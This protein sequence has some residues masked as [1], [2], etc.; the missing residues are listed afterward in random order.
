MTVLYALAITAE[1]G[2]AAIITAVP[3]NRQ[4]L[5]RTRA[6]LIVRSATSSAH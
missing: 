3:D 1:E 5:Q 4:S 6:Q 2:G